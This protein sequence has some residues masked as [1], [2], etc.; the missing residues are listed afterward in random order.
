FPFINHGITNYV[1]SS[2]R[3]LNNNG[4]DAYLFE[5]KETTFNKDKFSK[6][7]ELECSGQ[8]VEI[9]DTHGMFPRGSSDIDLHVRLHAP[10]LR[11]ETLN[12]K[13]L[14]KE[15]FNRELSTIQNSNYVS[16][17]TL[18]NTLAYE[19]HGLDKNKRV[20]NFPNPLFMDINKVKVNK[21]IDII[22]VARFERLKGIDFFFQFL[23]HLPKGLK[24]V[25]LGVKQENFSYFSKFKFSCDLELVGWASNEVKINYLARSKVCLMLS[26]FE[27]F[28]MV[29]AEGLANECHVVTWNIAGVAEAFSKSPVK[30]IKPFDVRILSASVLDLLSESQPSSNEII[31]FFEENNKKYVDGI[32]SLISESSPTLISNFD[33]YKPKNYIPSGRNLK[34]SA[35]NFVS[36][37]C[38]EKNLSFCGLSMNS[39]SVENMWGSLFYNGIFSRYSIISRKPL[40]TYRKKGFSEVFEVDPKKYHVIDWFDY[41]VLAAEK[42]KESDFDALIVFNGNTNKYRELISR[43]YDVKPITPV[44]TELGW[45]PQNNHI[46]FDIE[47][48]N[49]KS[50]IANSRLSDLIGRS[51]K[52]EIVKKSFSHS[53][54]VLLALQLPGDTT[55]MKE[56]FP[57]NLSNQSLI[58]HVRES[59]SKEIEILV[60]KHPMDKN[61]YRLESLSNISFSENNSFSDDLKGCDSL[62]AVNSTVVLEA[63]NYNINIYTFGFGVFSN[64]NLTIDCHAGDLKN[65]WISEIHF[66]ALARRNFISYLCKRQLNVLEFSKSKDIRNFSEA[67]YPLLFS[68]IKNASEKYL[69]VKANK[70]WGYV[71]PK[72]NDPINILEKRLKRLEVNFEKLI[73]NKE[74]AQKDIFS[75]N[76]PLKIRFKKKF[77]KLLNNPS[78]FMR[79]FFEKR[80]S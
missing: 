40:G 18:A 53:G 63:M 29:A 54:K 46:Y 64:K 42:I 3:V 7:I 8:I 32:K 66:D 73:S 70:P 23:F 77:I 22:F 26:R 39:E 35:D 24:V 51:Y 76:I 25:L 20:L 17:P 59:L 16:S 41:P 4:V 38:G 34:K 67:L 31:E 74:K 48:A 50:S 72:K 44:Y 19:E 12:Q 62:L 69:G 75:E 9:P 21:D 65:K 49:A 79:D 27:S 80:L 15:R 33:F 57:M 43:V 71:N 36:N 1:N 55:L 5:N 28:S 78:L 68:V 52:K 60:R 6:E 56:S 11:L 45:F 61:S 30:F 13:R 14:S 2:L 10:I 58:E 37:F 47:G